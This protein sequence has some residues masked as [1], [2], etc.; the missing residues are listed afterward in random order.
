MFYNRMCGFVCVWVCVSEWVYVFSFFAH[1]NVMIVSLRRFLSPYNRAIAL[2]R[3]VFLIYILRV[4]YFMYVCFARYIF[5]YRMY[6][7]NTSARVSVCG[8]VNWLCA[9]MLDANLIRNATVQTQ[10]VM[11]KNLIWRCGRLLQTDWSVYSMVLEFIIFFNGLF[12]IYS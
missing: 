3:V 12:V 4:C 5:I 1:I 6:E 2:D 8:C 9:Y 10:H 7:L 11:C